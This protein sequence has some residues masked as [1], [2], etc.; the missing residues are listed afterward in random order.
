MNKKFEIHISTNVET[1]DILAVLF[2]IRKGKSAETREIVPGLAFADYNRKG[3]LISVE[4]LGPCQ[5]N[6]LDKIDMEPD[7]VRFIK[8]SIPTALLAA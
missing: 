3:E 7:V 1:G 4:L 6:V 5:A 2:R 8:R